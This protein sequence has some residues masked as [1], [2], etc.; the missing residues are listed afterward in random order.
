MSV[1]EWTSAVPSG[2][3]SSA[4][5]RRRQT[6]AVVA[7]WLFFST[8]A[9]ASVVLVVLI[10]RILTQGWDALGW[11]LFTENISQT[12]SRIAEGRAGYRNGLISTLW[13]VAIAALFSIPIGLGAAI[14]L[15]EYAPNN[16]FTRIVTINISNLA[17][18]PSVVYGLLGLGVLVQFFTLDFLGPTVAA[19]GI[20][21]GLLVL[22]III[23]TSQEAIRA[24]P[25]SLRQAGYALGATQWQV[26]KSHVLPAAAP[27]ILTGTILAVARAVGETAPV[28]VA[29]AALY[30]TYVP[31]SL[32]DGYSPLPVQVFNL[33]GNAQA[34]IRTFAAAGIIMMLGLLILLNSVAIILRERAR[35]SVRW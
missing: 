9:F 15:E 19:G 1:G 14:Y 20:T 28:L 24:V 18:V 13:I 31:N 7:K 8:L 2:F 17:S 23:I 10:I 12:E 11:N 6:I 21:L 34:E 29:G 30:I 27:G 26:T 22:P 33:L 25:L 4:Y 16:L 5:L 35:R 32:G 3:S